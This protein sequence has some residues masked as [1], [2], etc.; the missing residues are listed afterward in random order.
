MAF[1]GSSNLSRSALENGV[2]WNYEVRETDRGWP[3]VEFIG[4]FNRL[5]DS[6]HSR[7]VTP[8]LIADYRARRQPRTLE[9]E[10]QLAVRPTIPVPRPAQVEA[11]T[12]LEALRTEG[13]TRGLVIAATGIGKTYLA[14][15]D[16]RLFNRVLFI[17]HRREILDQAEATFRA[18]RPFDRTGFYIGDRQDMDADLLFATVQTLGRA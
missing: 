15:F 6:P 10:E 4:H 9:E 2:E 17:A 11:L 16:S 8:D 13:E 18:V 3:L 1:V 5:F 7:P 12:Q 14:A